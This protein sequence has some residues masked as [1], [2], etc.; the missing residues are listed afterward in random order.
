[1]SPQTLIG[2]GDEITSALLAAANQERMV[3]WNTFVLEMKEQIINHYDCTNLNSYRAIWRRY[4]KGSLEK[5]Q[6]KAANSIEDVWNSIVVEELKQKR[7][8][9]NSSESEGTPY[10]SKSSTRSLDYQTALTPED[11]NILETKH[12]KLTKKW[13]LCSGRYVEDIVY[14]E[15]KNYAFD[16][17]FHSYIISL[18]D[19][20]STYE[21]IESC[22]N[23]MCFSRRTHPEENWLVESILHYIELFYDST[24][25]R[26]FASE[27]TLFDEMYSFVKTS[28]KINNTI[29][30]FTARSNAS[31]ESKNN[32]RSIGSTSK[33]NRQAVG[34]ISD[35]SFIYS[36][37]ELGC[38]EIG[39]ADN[40][41]NG[42]KEINEK[43]IKVPKMM[44]NFCWKLINDYKVDPKEIK[45][46][47]FVISGHY[48][49]N[50]IMTF[51]HGSIGLIY[52]SNRIKMPTTIKQISRLLPRALKIAYNSA[53]AIKDTIRYLDTACEDDQERTEEQLYFPPSFETVMKTSSSKKRK[54]NHSSEA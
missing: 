19:E 22:Y 46:V 2:I 31:S 33:I 23:N 44:R 43:N 36:N 17:P 40:G 37:N 49:T 38:V 12:L 11:M 47:G 51:K 27:S 30:E 34:D 9:A 3:D 26:T 25:A 10:S 50:T 28:K 5:L 1:M 35:L 24:S 7:S 54:P 52:N 4:F 29:T 8:S 20:N 48:M 42:T 21:E 53:R 32:S 15:G 14:E 45:V 16:H 13:K 18:D 39:L 6:L 41:G